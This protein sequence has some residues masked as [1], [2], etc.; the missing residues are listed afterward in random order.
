MK[1]CNAL[2][3]ASRMQYITIIGDTIGFER[4]KPAPDI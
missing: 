3:E 4:K 1:I 2:F